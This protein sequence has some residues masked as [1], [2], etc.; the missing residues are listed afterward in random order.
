MNGDTRI[1]EPR[2]CLRPTV[3]E[4]SS[5]HLSF[6]LSRT[7][8]SSFFLF[9]SPSL[10]LLHA[11]ALKKKKD[12]PLP[13][14]VLLSCRMRLLNPITYF[15]AFCGRKYRV[16]GTC[17]NDGR[18][19]RNAPSGGQANQSSRDALSLASIPF[20]ANQTTAW[21]TRDRQKNQGSLVEPGAS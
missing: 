7:R 15:P 10:F 8:A 13:F 20:P 12:I 4:T 1:P 2:K 19:L 18:W 11:L 6:F 14:C 5:S 17:E 3:P 9:L 16:W 21:D